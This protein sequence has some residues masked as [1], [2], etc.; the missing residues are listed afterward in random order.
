MDSD[1]DNL[2]YYTQ[3]RWLSKGKFV[4]RVYSLRILYFSKDVIIIFLRE[5]HMIELAIKWDNNKFI[6][7]FLYIVDMFY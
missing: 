5:Q 4:K 7:E 6:L 2:F 1:F 3:V